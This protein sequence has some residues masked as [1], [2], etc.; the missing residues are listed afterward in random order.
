MRGALGKLPG[1]G[2][3]DAKAGDMDFAVS[4]DS[5]T[6]QKDK[7]VEALKNAGYKDAGVKS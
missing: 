4:F 3:I 2:T 5:K 1:V 7:I 6:I